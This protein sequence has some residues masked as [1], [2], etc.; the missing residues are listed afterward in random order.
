MAVDELKAQADEKTAALAEAK[1]EQVRLME[2]V[3][4]L[5]AALVERDE[6]LKR[7]AQSNVALVERLASSESRRLI[8]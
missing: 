6:E 4:A 3:K 5:R 1:E 7:A 2:E 8:N